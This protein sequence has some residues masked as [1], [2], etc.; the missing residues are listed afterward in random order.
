MNRLAFLIFLLILLI[1]A[2]VCY[3]RPYHNWDMLAYMAC[4]ISIEES[5]IDSIHSKVYNTAQAELPPRDFK[6]LTT[7]ND[8]RNRNF[9]EAQFF[10]TRLS[11]YW[12]K[13]LYVLLV[14]LLYKAGIPLT[15]STLVPSLL[16]I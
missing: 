5:N 14:F 1:Q 11:L 4:A 9:T 13:P 6:E 12:V 15:V 2:A 10:Q 8:Y 16:S 3:L 7:A